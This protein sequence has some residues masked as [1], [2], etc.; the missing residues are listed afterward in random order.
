M[1]LYHDRLHLYIE[2][3]MAKYYGMNG[4]GILFYFIA[5]VVG[6]VDK[7]S[8]RNGGYTAIFKLGPRRGDAAEMAI[9]KLIGEGEEKKAVKEEKKAPK[10]EA[11][12]KA[13]E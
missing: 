3:M 10:A 5:S 4:I 2:E 8:E 13:A 7:Y 12:E 11:E 6:I 9:V 1:R